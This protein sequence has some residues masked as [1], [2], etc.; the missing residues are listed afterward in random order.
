MRNRARTTNKDITKKT[1]A[2]VKNLISNVQGMSQESFHKTLDSMV[3]FHQYSLFNQ[4]LLAFAGASQVA[5]FHKW[6]DLGR[7]VKK[8]QKAIW[9]LAPYF[10]R[11]DQDDYYNRDHRPQA[12]PQTNQDKEEGK[13]KIISGF[14]SVPV[15]DIAQTE[16]KE[17]ERGLTTFSP[18]STETIKTFAASQG[19]SVTFEPLE[20]NKGGYITDHHIVLNSNLNE[21][22]HA[23]TLVHEL[24]HGLLKHQSEQNGNTPAKIKEQQAEVTTYLVCKTLGIKRNSV[25]YLKAWDLSKDIVK[26]FKTID[27]TFKQILKGLTSDNNKEEQK[28]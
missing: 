2:T 5:G 28:L 13:I 10:K 6:K 9:I 4:F 14:F 26:D 16:G 3:R 21:A 18:V 8:G 27:R 7:T 23:G 25:F 22:E 1:L 17:I 20:I 15:F 19:Y 24:A 12:Q 11:I